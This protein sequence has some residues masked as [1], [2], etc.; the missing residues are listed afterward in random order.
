[1]KILI[2]NPEA[3]IRPARSVRRAV[4]LLAILAGTA[5]AQGALDCGKYPTV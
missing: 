1:M 2:A 5:L 4:S 3:K